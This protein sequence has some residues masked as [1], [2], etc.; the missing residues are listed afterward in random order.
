MSD[1]AVGGAPAA[2]A[3]AA[4]ATTQADPKGAPGVVKPKK[5]KAAP[6]PS[7][8][9]A[10]WGEKDEAA[11]FELFKRSPHSKMKVDGKEHT[12][13]SKE[14]FERMRLDA[15]RGRGASRL[16]EETKREAADAK[17]DREEATAFRDLVKRAQAGDKEARRALRLI[18][19]DEAEEAQRNWDAL[20]PRIKAVIERNR[21]LETQA[22]ERQRKDE[23]AQQSEKQR[24]REAMKA[25]LLA[26]ARAH[27]AEI[28]ADVRPES[29]DVELP[30]IIAAMRHLHD[31]KLRLGV[32]YGVEQLKQLVSD[33]RT[34]SIDERIATL[35][36]EAVLKHA[37]K[38]L[39]E[40]KPEQLQELLGG[41]LDE[42]GRLF[43]RAY[44]ERHRAAK[45]KPPPAQSRPS[46]PPRPPQPLSKFRF[47]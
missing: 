29:M 11:F 6:A 46:E 27:A 24:K 15:I 10:P 40:L 36:P 47:G 28:L 38:A 14:D 3:P 18:P 43:S 41:D 44:I 9:P 25:E 4:D 13:S 16:V 37:T 32:D 39:R 23:E 19:D 21:E 1:G 34:R 2:P 33:E 30:N 35:K 45:N 26:K 31:R 5:G 7:P 22:E 20:D 42:L 17:R 12:I 8:E